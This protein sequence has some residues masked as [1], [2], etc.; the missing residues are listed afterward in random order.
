MWQGQI[1]AWHYK[2]HFLGWKSNLLSTA[3]VNYV[4]N[5][6]KV[7]IIFCRLSEK[8]YLTYFTFNQAIYPEHIFQLSQHILSGHGGHPMWL[9]TVLSLSQYFLNESSNFYMV[10]D[11]KYHLESNITLYR[12]KFTNSHPYVSTTFV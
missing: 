5:I 8:G 9:Y 6:E 12:Q 7:R 2:D 3:L 10:S 4:T 1:H 11:G